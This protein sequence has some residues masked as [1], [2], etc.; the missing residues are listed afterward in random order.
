MK[1]F[2]LTENEKSL[3]LK[4][5]RRAIEGGDLKELTSLLT[6]N[7]KIKSGVFVTL[8]TGGEQLRGCIGNFNFNTQIYQNV[9]DMAKE[10]AFNDHRFIPLKDSELQNIKIEISVL[11]PLEKI[12]N[13]DDIEIGRH[14]LYFIKGQYRGVLL[15]QVAVEHNMNKKGFLEA[16]SMKAGL[17]SD[18]YKTGADIFTF[19]ALVFGE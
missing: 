7:L 16:V 11:T 5:A 13:F 15:P 14:G 10:A 17:P 8:K 2:D 1:N 18:A 3:L 19:S 4:I 6:D 12:D 9:Y